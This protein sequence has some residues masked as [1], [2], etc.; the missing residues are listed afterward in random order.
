MCV[1]VYVFMGWSW[2][3]SDGVVLRR[4]QNLKSWKEEK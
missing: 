3:K 4:K 2:E 1:Y